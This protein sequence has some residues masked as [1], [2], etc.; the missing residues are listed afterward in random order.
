MEA[1]F[2]PFMVELGLTSSEAKVYLAAVNLGAATTTEIAVAAGKERSNT[3]HL[4]ERLEQLGLVEAS[5]DSPTRFKPIELGEAVDHLFSLESVK[6][7]KLDERRKSV[8]ASLSSKGLGASRDVE[9]Y[10]VIKGRARTYLRMVESI[11]D[12]K[13]EVSL[14][15]S[16]NGVTRLRRFGDFMQVMKQRSRA[17][18]QFRVITEIN[19]SNSGDVKAFGRLAEVRHVRNQSTNAS[20]YDSKV[21]SVALVINDNLD[22]DAPEHVALWTNGGSFVRMLTDFFDSVWFVAAP[23]QPTLKSMGLKR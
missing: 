23:A 13:K 17:G 20:V 11:S 21:G 2:L 4:L 14:L 9:T 19:R 1:D 6:F 18:V 8:L 5:L 15:L 10:S 16:A 12:C 7:R 3:H 22:E